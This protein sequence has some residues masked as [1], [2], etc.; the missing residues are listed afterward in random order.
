MSVFKFELRRMFSGKAN[1]LSLLVFLLSGLLAI[2]LGALNYDR[3]MQEQQNTALIFDKEKEQISGAAQ[4]PEVGSLAYYASVPTQWQLS[5]WAALFSGQ[6]QYRLTAR[7]LQALALQ[8]QIYGRELINPARS[9]AG[10]FDLGFV[11]AYLLPILIGILTVSLLSEER[12]SGRWRMLNAL[13]AHTGARLIIRALLLRFALVTLLVCLLFAVAAVVARVPLD[14][15]FVAFVGITLLYCLLWFLIAGLIISLNRDSL[16][17]NLAFLSVWLLLAVLLPGLVHLQQGRSFDAQLPLKAA[18]EQRLVMN[19][20]WDQDMHQALVDFAEYYP[21]FTEQLEFS[22]R[23]HWKWYFAMQH[24]SDQAVEDKWQAYLMEHRARDR[25]LDKVSL[26]SPSLLLQR[27]LYAMA[28]TDSQAYFAYLEQ[29]RD[30]HRQLREFV[31][32]YL[33][34]DRQMDADD[35]NAFP[36]FVAQPTAQYPLPLALLLLLAG[37]GALLTWRFNRLAKV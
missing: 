19:N 5:P 16:Y 31:Y 26:L 20:G 13:S 23:F 8:G 14:G 17:N 11:L 10:G 33:F 9:R 12:Q 1:N 25:Q 21:Q 2:Y 6:S 36:A 30:F 34:A 22:G 3:Q 28:G 27:Y 35:F 32:P 15:L 29:V 24:L 7:R 37:L 18:V 4:I